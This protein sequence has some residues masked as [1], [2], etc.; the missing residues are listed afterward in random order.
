MDSKQEIPEDLKAVYASLQGNHKESFTEVDVVFE[1]MLIERIASLEAAL[2]SRNAEY[3]DLLGRTADKN[4]AILNVQSQLTSAR[5]QVEALNGQLLDKQKLYT[6][7]ILRGD[8]LEAQLAAVT[9]KVTR[10]ELEQ[11][12]RETGMVIIPGDADMC[13]KIIE[14]RASR[15]QSRQG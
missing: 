6:D 10:E 11:V 2:K 14:N 5:E 9:G 3:V 1:R 7:A 15:T 4:T 13:S 8:D 12:S